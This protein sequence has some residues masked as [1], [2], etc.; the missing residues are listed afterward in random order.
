MPSKRVFPKTV[1]MEQALLRHVALYNHQLPQSALQSKT[2]M[3][4]MKDRHQTQPHLLH[5]RPY[6]RPGYGS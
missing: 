1:G 2:P 3:Q 6:D 4:A 5:K